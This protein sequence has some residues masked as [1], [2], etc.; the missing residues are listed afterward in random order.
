MNDAGEIK[1]TGVF[2][3]GDKKTRTGKGKK[4]KTTKKKILNTI[5]VSALNINS[6]RCERMPKPELIDLAKK[7]GVV[8]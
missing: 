1:I 4:A 3:E 8:G 7:L 6:T 5:Q 2:S